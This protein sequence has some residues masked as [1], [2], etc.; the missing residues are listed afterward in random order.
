[1]TLETYDTAS[2]MIALVIVTAQ[3]V[4]RV[5]PDSQTGFLGA[6]RKVAK[7]IGFYTGNRL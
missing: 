2:G 1:M 4:G 6:V 3:I 5:I 7:A